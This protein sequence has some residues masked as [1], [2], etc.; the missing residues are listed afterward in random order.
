M[1]VVGIITNSSNIIELE[2]KLNIIVINEKSIENMKNVKFDIVIIYQETKQN[3]NIKQLISTCKYLVINT[4]IKENLK[5]LEG[6]DISETTIITYGFN[7]K[8][9]ITIVSNENDEIILEIQREINNLKGEKI[10]CQEIK[11][12]NNLEKNHIYLA[13]SLKILE[14]LKEI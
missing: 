7:R 4:D 5:L 12:Q 14:I 9:S 2:N 3:E 1:S 10:E 13:I 11:L 6:I 8:S